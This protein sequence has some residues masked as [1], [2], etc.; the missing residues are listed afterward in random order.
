MPN[1][2]DATDIGKAKFLLL[3]PTGSGK[4]SQILTL[5]GKTFCYL[6]DP[7]SLATLKGHDIEYELFLPGK[8][9]TAAVSLSKGK[10]DRMKE[11]DASET[12]TAWEKD[13]DEK[14]E[15]D[16]DGKCYFD[17]FDN[18]CFDSFT[19]FSDVVMD[20]VLKLNGRAGKF[21]QQDDWGGQ[22]QT[23][24]NVV[25]TYA[26]MDKVLLF[27]AHEEFKQDAESGRM[28]NIILLT[29]RLRVKLPLLFSEMLHMEC[30]S[31]PAEIKYQI[32]TRPDRFN[33]AIRC[34]MRDLEMFHD[35]TIKEWDKPQ[36]YGIGKLLKGTKR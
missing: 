25:R 10:S 34:T 20:R 32:Q 36:N 3:G 9:S 13:S 14:T 6:F 4:T 21:P 7:S 12:Y 35:V 11:E 18:I 19:T 27:T 24:T 15:K 8:V 23:I 30:A 22:M 33:P 31:T 16:K 17:Q 2:K 26:S 29:G 1:A 5:P 28:V